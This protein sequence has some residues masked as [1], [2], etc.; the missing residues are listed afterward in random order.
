MAEVE[1]DW[2]EHRHELQ[3]GD[4][5]HTDEGL[6]MLDRRVPGD[7]TQ[8]YVADWFDGWSYMDS[9]IEPGDLNRRGETPKRKRAEQSN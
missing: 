7:G 4:I 2:Y 6:V 5:F 9:T 3:E 8:W 1:K